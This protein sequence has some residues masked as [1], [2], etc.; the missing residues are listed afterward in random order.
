[1]QRIYVLLIFLL[2]S[3]SLK[4][5]NLAVDYL[6]NRTSQPYIP[7]TDDTLL[8]SGFQ[9]DVLWMGTNLSSGPVNCTSCS[10]T[11]PGFPIGFNFLF[12]GNN[13]SRWG[14]SSNGYIKLGNGEF[15][16]RNSLASAFST[17]GDSSENVN[18]IAALHGDIVMT[19]IQGS[20]RYRTIGSPGSRILV[21]EYRAMKHWVPTITT[22]EVFNFQI[23]LHEGSNK[24]SFAYG[25]FLKDGISRT[26]D[27]GIRGRYFNDFH[28]RNLPVTATSWTQNTRGLNVNATMA[29]NTEL[30]PIDGMVFNFIPRQYENDLSLVEILSPLNGV[31]SCP[32]SANEPVR[33]KIKNDGLL[34]QSSATVGFRVGNGTAITQPV[35]F[36]PPLAAQQSREISLTP[37]A[38]LTGFTPPDLTAFVF[39][40]TEEEGSRNN[41]SATIKFT[42]GR[43][44]ETARVSSFD[45]LTDDYGWSRGRGAAIPL[46]NYSLWRPSNSFSVN[47]SALEMRNDTPQVKNEWFY[48]PGYRVDTS[49]NYALN[50][51]AAIT[52][53]L[54]GTAAITDIGDDTI[55]FM[56]STDCRQT[57]KLLKKFST[58]DLTSGEINNTLKPF[59]AFLPPSVK[60]LVTFGFF[61][62]NNGNAF[63]NAYRFHFRNLHLRKVVRFDVSA[64]TVRIPS[65]V[66]LSCKYSGQE[67]LTLKITNKGFEPLDSTDAGFFINGGLAIRKKFGF[68]P[69][70]QPGASTTLIFSGTSGADMSFQEGQAITA[71]VSLKKEALEGRINDTVRY[72]YGLISPL[73]IPTPVYPTYAATAAARWQRARGAKVPSGNFSTWGQKTTFP[74]NPTTGMDFSA[75]PSTLQEWFYSASYSGPSIVK[76]NFKAAVTGIGNTN[77]VTG[78][79]EDTLKVLY[80]VD[81]GVSWNTIKSFSGQDLSSNVI[82]NT[83]KEFSY[84]IFSTRGSIL[85]GFAGFRKPGAPVSNGFTFH[86][87]SI[88]INAPSFPDF[89]A[90]SI[91][92]GIDGTSTCPGSNPVTVAVVV[93]NSGSI[94]IPSAI[95]GYKVNGLPKTK[96]VNFTAPG[97]AVGKLDTVRF[98]GTDAPVYNIA[99]KYLLKGFVNLSNEAPTTAFNDS[100]SENTFTLFAKVPVPYLENFQGVGSLPIGWVADTASGKGFK[101]TLGRGPAGS[102]AL[103]FRS[104]TGAT[105]ANLITRNFG[106]ITPTTN[107]LGLAYRSQDNTN[108]LFRLRPSDYIDVMVSSNCGATYDF[109]GRIDSVNQLVAAGFLA[110]DFPLAAYVGQDITVKLDVK[111][112]PKA[113]QTVFLDI[114]KFSIGGPTSVDGILEG[115]AEGVLLYPNPA[116]RQSGV[117]IQSDKHFVSALAFGMSGQQITLPITSENDGIFKISTEKLTQGIY[118]LILQGNTGPVRLRLVVEK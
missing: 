66:S 98:T 13:F 37:T 73:T 51:S 14:F 67:T 57:W 18:I 105:R 117:T 90:T 108:A 68:S 86:V 10:L 6:F 78:M 38:N 88:S 46:G 30:T 69:L 97:L 104:Q 20:F 2:L 53:G 29:T 42:V 40:P 49:F 11:G 113:F 16:I 52:S 63:A 75:A 58:E 36:T 59:E 33:V 15:T 32:L 60:Q 103:S 83:L 112:T 94:P 28:L 91:L 47:T 62:K 39:I 80:S 107:F 102:Q 9:D 26:Y 8:G 35:T 101:H 34:A 82:S 27:V 4:A 100:S 45:T 81:C 77:E 3:L 21:V 84:E 7:L 85:F 50:F 79:N 92:P 106:V 23:R 12:D 114:S 115:N 110:K 22:E 96:L 72:S 24:I 25:P 74:N 17:T 111:I 93:R 43:P 55:K 70:L 109:L 99:G 19:E 116:S 54:T 89:S 31:N 71:F 41:D 5:Q 95:V 44:F 64:D 87:D 65:V 1:M 76:L 48:S 61:G 56:Y 118:I